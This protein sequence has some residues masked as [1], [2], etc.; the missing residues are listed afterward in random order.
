MLERL[1]DVFNLSLISFRFQSTNLLRLNFSY[2][3][4]KVN[5][6]KRKEVKM[7]YTPSKLL[8]FEEFWS[9]YGDDLRYELIDEW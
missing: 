5:R 7:T 1:N 2:E 6:V 3:Y 8:S 9:H 4:C